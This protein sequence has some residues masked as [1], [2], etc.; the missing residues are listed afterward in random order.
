MVHAGKGI[1]IGPIG[2]IQ[3]PMKKN[4]IVEHVRIYVMFLK[5]KKSD[6]LNFT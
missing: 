4:D 5:G 3:K 2:H 1:T 6:C